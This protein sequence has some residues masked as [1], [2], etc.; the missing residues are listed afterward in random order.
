MMEEI[1][2]KISEDVQAQT[3]KRMKNNELILKLI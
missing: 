3:T 2:Q 1:E